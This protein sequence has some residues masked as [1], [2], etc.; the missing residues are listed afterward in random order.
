MAK[1]VVTPHLVYKRNEKAMAVKISWAV[2][3]VAVRRVSFE[4]DVR[5]FEGYW[6][7]QPSGTTMSTAMSTDKRGT[8]LAEAVECGAE[9]VSAHATRHILR[10]HDAEVVDRRRRVEWDAMTTSGRP[11]PR[12]PMP[13]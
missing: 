8:S 12:K 13:D 11:A 4:A 7:M 1:A 5:P 6:L 3:R 2:G 9:W 10:Q